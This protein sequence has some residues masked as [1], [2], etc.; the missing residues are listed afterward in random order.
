[1]IGSA[2]TLILPRRAV[3]QPHPFIYKGGDCGACSL[4]G[5]LGI[6]V[7]EVYKAFGSDGITH[8]GE[9]GR[10]LR[11]AV[12]DY[13]D[14]ILDV[15]AKWDVYTGCASFGQPAYFASVP[16]FNYIRMGIDAGYYGL[17]TI[18]YDGNGRPE[19]NHWIV[20]CGARTKG[21]IVNELITGDILVS[22]SVRGECWYDAR[23]FLKNFGGY[24]TMLVRPKVIC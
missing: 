22:C 16:W 15:P 18:N 7:P 12:T 24:D 19:T 13:A 6:S 2:G 5:V 9:M 20:I 23:E 21:A 3:T 8:S 14:R 11:C 1:M 4:G 17:A 10:C